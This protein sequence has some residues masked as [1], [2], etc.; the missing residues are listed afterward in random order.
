MP[1]RLDAQI[2]AAAA[3]NVAIVAALR[4][5]MIGNDDVLKTPTCQRKRQETPATNQMQRFVDKVFRFY[6]DRLAN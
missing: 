4:K 6:D 3:V 1:P 5:Q 2:N